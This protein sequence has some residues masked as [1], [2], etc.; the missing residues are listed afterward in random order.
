MA[1]TRAMESRG[2]MPQPMHNMDWRQTAQQIAQFN[3]GIKPDVLAG[4][5]ERVM[6]MAAPQ[7]RIEFL[8]EQLRQRSLDAA[9]NRES[10]EKI[11]A[12]GQSGDQYESQIKAVLKGDAA[13]PSPNSRAP[14][15]QYVRNEVFRRNPEFDEKTYAGARAGE[16]A[17]G[18]ARGGAEPQADAGSLKRM[19]AQADAIDA[20]SSTANRVGKVLSTLADKVDTTGSPVIERWIRAGRKNVAGD[21]DVAKFNA[22]MQLYRAEVAKILTNP[23]LTGVL[24]NYAQRE[25]EQFLSGSSSAKQIK[26][27]IELLENDFSLRKQETDKKVKEIKGRLKGGGKQQEEESGAP[28]VGDVV[29]GYRFKGGDPSKKESWEKE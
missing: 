20:F 22:Q 23:N 13:L 27:L 18:R 15:A 21:V 11:A 28:K 6:K 25:V 17:G 1:Q 19:V 12:G 29:K 5:V 26:G 10:H 4:A 3:P 14:G 2:Q 7:Y 16:V 8:E 24:T 9:L